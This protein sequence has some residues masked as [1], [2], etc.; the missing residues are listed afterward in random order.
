[1]GLSAA[2]KEKMQSQSPAL[3]E[4]INSIFAPSCSPRAAE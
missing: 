2:F 1:M 3:N 4:A